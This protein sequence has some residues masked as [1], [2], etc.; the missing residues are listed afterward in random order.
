VTP[1]T[2][3]VE[4]ARLRLDGGTQMRVHL[5][6][7]AVDAYT[8]AMTS[9]VL[10][11]PVDVFSDGG[12]LWLADG[13][14]RVDAARLAGVTFI[15]AV[16]H[17]GTQRDAV[18]FAAAANHQHGVQRTPQDKRLAVRT[19]LDDPEWS[20]WADKEIARRCGV[21]GVFV[22]DVR[23]GYRSRSGKSGSK[24]VSGQSLS[25]AYS[26]APQPQS[27][28]PA[29]DAIA[30]TY[31]S[32]TGAPAVMNVTHIGR[33]VT[34]KDAARSRYEARAAAAADGAS[35]HVTRRW[36][37][38][39]DRETIVRIMQ[40]LEQALAVLERVDVAALA[41]EPQAAQWR[42]TAAQMVGAMRAFNRSL[43]RRSA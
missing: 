35:E 12:T 30:R 37:T 8:A 19:L 43:E 16:I 4:I 24:S 20:K 27:P 38:K 21:S 40:M 14:H 11:P 10:L 39:S 3:S 1:A 26:V 32:K 6:A 13:F 9:G 22:G 5:S 29:D 15:T 36:A 34:Q 18:L 42:T 2:Q 28:A 23:R 33:R 25:P 31:R 41:C 17:P 7:A